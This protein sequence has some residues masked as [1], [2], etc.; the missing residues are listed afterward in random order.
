MRVDGA[1]AR[2]I[3]VEAESSA[4]FVQENGCGS[5]L[6][7]S[8]ARPETDS[9]NRPFGNEKIPIAMAALAEFADVSHRN[10]SALT[11]HSP[12]LASAS[13]PS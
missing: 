11:G 2:A 5:A 4:D 6:T 12:P 1:S 13:A 9:S 3:D 10:Q 7:A 8:P